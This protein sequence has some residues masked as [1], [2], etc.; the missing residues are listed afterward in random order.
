[1]GNRIGFLLAT[2]HQGAGSTFWK[3]V[4][5]EALKNKNDALFV[6]PGGRLDYSAENEHLK[7]QIYSLVNRDNLDGAIVWTSSLTGAVD[8]EESARFVKAKSEYIPIVSIG[9]KVDGIPTVD[10]D[11]YEGLYQIV[12]HLAEV[13][14]LKKIAYL[15]GPN[16][17]ESSERRFKAYKDALRDNRIPFNEKLVTPPLPWTSGED[18]IKELVEKRCLVPGIDFDA[19][20]APSDMMLFHAVKYLE[21]HGVV[22]P[23]NLKTAGFND[24]VEN[25]LNSVAATTVKMP[26]KELASHSYA[27]VSSLLI[28]QSDS[29]LDE[30]LPSKL[31]LRQSCG[32]QDSFGGEENARK[33]IADF[34]DLK[35]WLQRNLDSDAAYLAI[36]SILDAL[37]LKA[38]FMRAEKIRDLLDNYFSVGGSAA[39]LLESFKWCERILSLSLH[40]ISAKDRLYNL[41]IEQLARSTAGK[42]YEDQQ[43]VKMLNTF[44]NGL[45][46]VSTMDSLVSSVA[47]TLP[48]LGVEKLFICLY[49]DDDTT[50]LKG[51]FDESGEISCSKEFSRCLILDE[52]YKSELDKGIFIIEPLNYLSQELG[53]LII[54]TS[55]TEGYVLEDIRSSISSSLKGISLFE[56]ESRRSENAERA[57]K[58][59]SEFYL[60][61]SEGLKE[62]LEALYALSKAD[63]VDKDA[64]AL[65][66]VKAEHL[67]ELSM[68]EKG[69]VELECSLFPPNYLEEKLSNSA[70]IAISGDL[71]A[72]YADR[73]K[74][75]DA[76]NIVIGFIE[77]SGDE[78]EVRFSSYPS[79]LYIG[80]C[81]KNG[82]WKPSMLSDDP[83]RLLF[84]RIILMHSGSFRFSSSEIGICLPYPSLSSLSQVG[85]SN[86]TILFITGDSDDEA[87]ESL[88]SFN[89][90]KKQDSELI[91][92]FALPD[93]LSSILWNLSASHSSKNVLLNLL[94]NYKD[95]KDVPFLILNLKEPTMSLV[96]AL[97]LS[98]PN[99]DKAVI[100]SAGRFPDSLSRLSEFGNVVEVDNPLRIVDREENASL[101]ILYDYDISIV[102][103]LR[104]SKR[105]MRTPI[106][107]SKDEFDMKEA[108]ELKEVPNVLIVNTCI[109]ESEEFISRLIGIFGGGE[110]LPPLTSALVKK[111]IAYLN[112]NASLQIS[113]WQLA[114]AVNISEDYLTRIFRKEIGISPWDYL[115]RYRIQLASKMLTQTGASVNEIARDIGFQDQAYF[116]R[117]FKKIK[118]FPPG[119]L[120]ART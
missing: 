115:N 34:D 97:E 67:L 31:I 102:N 32:C 119:H 4:A 45:L 79:Y 63:V 114:A 105:F 66:V 112:K 76:L 92:S 120:R 17:H 36:V 51:G 90:I 98:T 70:A 42:S 103:K 84:E 73:D 58:E 99:E 33:A 52:D 21:E 23:D 57:E 16:S 101:I 27:M 35:K 19:L 8:A 88:S 80:I 9:Q 117:V 13:H 26:I 39:I 7:N 75:S 107:I 5:A 25:N 85:S 30:M 1:M 12:N 46:S 109:L 48:L 108:D 47:K 61:L 68:T 87:P 15:R 71:P 2:L 74:L 14:G 110:L 49:K 106:L 10:F 38:G 56:D 53:Y 96:A 60:N 20:V 69:G 59:I 118:G 77:N 111:S 81:G 86:G 43:V 6:F 37:Y 50:V 22:V 28:G 93:D 54:K 29:M 11:S 55:R 95:T 40:D 3:L 116:C 78:V 24:T 83:S 64:L 82:K 91:E 89:I 94:K 104:G 65:N 62:P 100:I 113:R 41:I 18:A 44:K 72:I